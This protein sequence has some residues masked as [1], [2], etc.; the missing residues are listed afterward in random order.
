MQK[1]K[2]YNL[3]FR[4]SSTSKPEEKFGIKRKSNSG[5]KIASSPTKKL[6]LHQDEFS[7]FANLP[8]V[9]KP[10]PKN[11]Q[12]TTD[13]V[14]KTDEYERTIGKMPKKYQTGSCAKKIQPVMDRL[15][16]P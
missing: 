13:T 15:V 7:I 4:K 6:K 3:S 16:V 10:Y 14:E 9:T 5:S 8:G 1:K 11:H 2:Y 12:Q